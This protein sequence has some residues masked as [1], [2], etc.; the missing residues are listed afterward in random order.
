MDK[1]RWVAEQDLIAEIEKHPELEWF[2]AMGASDF[3]SA[4]IRKLSEID[5][6]KLMEIR[7]FY[8]DYEIKAVRG[9]LGENEKFQLRDSIDYQSMENISAEKEEH[10]LDI[11][12][13]KKV[14]ITRGE[15][16]MFIVQATGGGTYDLPG[17]DVD[18][19]R[20]ENFYYEDEKGFSYPFDFRIVEFL[21]EGE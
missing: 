5:L 21:K 19:I 14:P 1:R 7:A 3:V 20:I 18:K 11:D 12:T 15:S 17:M 2:I 13:S 9:C 6:S 4:P 16:D 10:Y 8:A